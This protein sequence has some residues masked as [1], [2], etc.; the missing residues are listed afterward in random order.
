MLLASCASGGGSSSDNKKPRKPIT[1]WPETSVAAF[2]K[3][4]NSLGKD[5]ENAR[6]AFAEAIELSPNMEA[7]YYN[8]A[9]LD[10]DQKNF[11]SVDNFVAVVEQN[12]ATSAR[13]WNLFG[14]SKRQQSDFDSAKKY[15]LAAIKFDGSYTPALLNIAILHDVYL[16]DFVTA[17]NY[18]LQ[19]QQQLKKQGKDDNRLKN[20][21]TDLQRRNAAKNGSGQ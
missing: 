21:L 10:L 20:W 13:L 2:S 14:T 12:D 3:G 5:N 19:Y 17:Q 18:Y 16:G 1:D 11:D 9:K 15:Y 6:L 4:V 7:A 8:L